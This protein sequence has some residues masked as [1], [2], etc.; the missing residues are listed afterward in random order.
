MTERVTQIA[1]NPWKL[2][3]IGMALVEIGRAHV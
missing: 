3:A 1:R 2:T